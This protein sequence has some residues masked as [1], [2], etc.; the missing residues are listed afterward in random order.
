MSVL[1]KSH[2][3][4]IIK[5]LCPGLNSSEIEE[6]KETLRDLLK[7]SNMLP[8]HIKTNGITDKIEDDIPSEYHGSSDSIPS[9][10][11]WVHPDDEFGDL[12]EL[13]V[14]SKDWRVMNQKLTYSCV[15]FAIADGLFNFYA[16]KVYQ[17]N[18]FVLNYS[19]W[20]RYLKLGDS[21]RVTPYLKIRKRYSPRFVWMMGKEN[22][23]NGQPASTAD[24]T[25]G[26]DLYI[27]LR[28]CFEFKQIAM[29]KELPLKS[30]KTGFLYDQIISDGGSNSDIPGGA[31]LSN[32]VGLFAHASDHF[33][34]SGIKNFYVIYQIQ[35]NIEN[36][37]FND[38][39]TCT[40][41]WL[42]KKGPVAL[43]LE[44]GE[45]F[46]NFELP[47]INSLEEAYINVALDH[48]LNIQNF[49]EPRIN[50]QTGI[51]E[52]H[53]NKRIKVKR[54]FHS[55]TVVGYKDVEVLVNNKTVVRE[56]LIIK[57]SWGKKWGYKG[58]AMLSKEYLSLSY[59][60]E[61]KTEPMDDDST[62]QI[63]R[64]VLNKICTIN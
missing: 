18:N 42:L 38:A 63:I 31:I 14:Q 22:D 34:Q 50:F 6:K 62:E 47:A 30:K 46:F 40:K 60:Y 61:Y 3:D 54:F 11:S 27:A 26:T 13:P 43:E 48:L 12:S 5:K 37:S 49:P 7:S 36:T 57:N 52:W 9:Y 45:E 39:F 21:N 16:N 1:F 19:T 24:D 23:F 28:S 56:Y 44:I 35:N 33:I 59:Q 2:I 51:G 15:G 8:L 29:A 53:G 4:Q 25:R 64:R 10:W 58:Y 55:V 17:K 32:Q 41:N 20:N